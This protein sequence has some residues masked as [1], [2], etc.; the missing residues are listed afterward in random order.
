MYQSFL[1]LLRERHNITVPIIYQENGVSEFNNLPKATKQVR[2]RNQISLVCA[3][4]AWAVTGPAPSGLPVS[5]ALT[6]M[7]GRM[8]VQLGRLRPQD[9]RL[10]DTAYPNNRPSI[11]SFRQ[12]W[13]NISPCNWVRIPRHLP[14]PPLCL[15]SFWAFV[16]PVTWPHPTSSVVFSY[17]GATVPAILYI[18]PELFLAFQQTALFSESTLLIFLTFI[19]IKFSP[20]G[21]IILTEL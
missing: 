5:R 2:D 21:S 8:A 14:T 9:P 13:P 17:H 18:W 1:L 6:N 10:V 16:V 20:S 12:Q 3:C 4:R 11:A 7:A 19:S 15:L